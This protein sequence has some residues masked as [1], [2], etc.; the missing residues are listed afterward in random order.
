M[1]EAATTAWSR[2]TL[3]SAIEQ[4]LPR[5]MRAPAPGRACRRNVSRSLGHLLCCGKMDEAVGVR[6]AV[7]R[8][9]F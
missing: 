7:P 3:F 2:C 9:L 8:L 1:N 4:L 6:E 5:Y